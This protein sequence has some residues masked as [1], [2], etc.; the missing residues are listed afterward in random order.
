MNPRCN[1]FRTL[2]KKADSCRSIRGIRENSECS[3]RAFRR[4]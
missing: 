3:G 4:S 1:G 2:A